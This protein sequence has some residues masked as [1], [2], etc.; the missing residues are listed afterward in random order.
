MSTRPEFANAARYI[1]TLLIF[2]VVPASAA[3]QTAPASLV[4]V[5]LVE[6]TQG[7]CRFLLE[8]QGR[9]DRIEPVHFG[10]DRYIFDLIP[11][12]WNGATRR[13]NA[14]IPGIKEYR[15]SQ[16]SHNPIAAR[17][18]VEVEHGWSC[19]GEFAPRGV[20]VSCEGLRPAGSDSPASDPTVAVVRGMDLMSPLAGLDAGDLIERSIGYTPQNL[21]RD[22]LPNFGSAR[23]DWKDAARPH[24][25][26]DFYVDKTP[27]Q[28]V[29]DGEV[30]GVGIGR[31][32]GGW[33][34]LRHG[35]G[36]ETVYVHIS[37]IST[38]IGAEVSAGQTIAAVDGAVGNAIEPQL[39]FE[40]RLDGEA[41]D[42]IP[43][44]A[45]RASA[46]LRRTITRA[47]RRLEQLA[48]ERAVAVRIFPHE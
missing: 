3:A 46:D 4:N 42:F 6:S 26:V 1:W 30:V 40:L 35:Q 32:A 19:S 27:V 47:Q 34:K 44:I 37:G 43:F 14:Q 13:F 11:V 10:D 20:E 48:E 9:V 16:F 45:A 39:H 23:D 22:G 36:V 15:F 28:A 8:V 17:F 25:G 31:R 29:A 18:V 2:L 5:E 21:V 33:L 38:E 24:Q 41:V 7:G 12:A